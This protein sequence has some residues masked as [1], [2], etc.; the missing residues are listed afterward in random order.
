MTTRQ[1]ARYM[2]IAGLLVAA[3]SVLFPD[4][5]F[6]SVI[7]VWIGLGTALLFGPLSLVVKD[8]VIK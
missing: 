3:A 5:V 7:F 4:V 6:G 1:F 2:V 8:R